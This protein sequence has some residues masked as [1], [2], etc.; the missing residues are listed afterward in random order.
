MAAGIAVLVTAGS[1]YISQHTSIPPRRVVDGDAG[2]SVIGSVSMVQSVSGMHISA[3]HD[4]RVRTLAAGDKLFRNDCIVV[5]PNCAMTFRYLNESTSIELGA[6]TTLSV[7][8]H[9]GA[10]I[11]RLAQGRLQAT[12]A[13]QQLGRP[14]LVK[15]HDAEITVVGT[16][17]E[18]VAREFTQLKVN[19]GK[20][21]F[22]SSPH[23]QPRLVK[24][25]ETASSRFVEDDAQVSRPR[26]IRY[27]TFYEKMYN[28][29]EVQGLLYADYGRSAFSYLQFNLNYP[30]GE[31][32]SATLKLRVMPRN[33]DLWGN[34]TLLVQTTPEG[35]DIKAVLKASR[36]EIGRFSGKMHA[37]EDIVIPLDPAG[38]KRGINTLVIFMEKGGN[39]VWFSSSSGTAA[40]EL[41]LQL[42]STPETSA[43]E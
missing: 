39:D 15:T 4:G 27:H 38:L 3:V 42:S 28:R 24:S 1:I 41:E 26:M 21:I 14:M 10:K 6:D 33:D 17:F 2:A 16:A 11:I 5:P 43:S 40:P 12:V 34:G 23:N 9:D 37:G 13:R 29:A 31:I 25:G 35:T 8:V 7:H 19:T 32:I 36:T 30:E 20:V 22:R 18:V